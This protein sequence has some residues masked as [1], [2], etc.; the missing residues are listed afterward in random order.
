MGTQRLMIIASAILAY[1]MFRDPNDLVTTRER[2]QKAK[3]DGWPAAFRSLIE[4][5][6]NEPTRR[7]ALER[8]IPRLTAIGDGTSRI[9]RAMYE[10]NP[11]PRWLDLTI[12]AVRL[13][14]MCC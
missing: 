12:P 3:F 14:P 13:M 4:R 11:Y 5:T 9:V 7:L 6:V 1:A 10:A 2:V 8:F